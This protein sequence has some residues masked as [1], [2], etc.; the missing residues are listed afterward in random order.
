MAYTQ[1]NPFSRK[2]PLKSYADKFMAS[3]QPVMDDIRQDVNEFAGYRGRDTW[4]DTVEDAF[5]QAPY[6][7]EYGTDKKYPYLSS[8]HHT[9]DSI[10]NPMLTN[11]RRSEIVDGTE[12]DEGILTIAEERKRNQDR[13]LGGGGRNIGTR[14]STF[15]GPT[16]NKPSEKAAK[17][18]LKRHEYLMN[19]ASS[20]EALKAALSTG[21]RPNRH[22]AMVRGEMPVREQF[23][24]DPRLG[25]A[26]NI[27]QSY[28]ANPGGQSLRNIHQFQDLRDRASSAQ[29][30]T[31]ATRQIR[32]RMR[33][34]PTLD[35]RLGY[36]PRS[37]EGMFDTRIG[38]IY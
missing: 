15:F 29:D 31:D 8:R 22:G 33:F 7:P 24:I 6:A 26:V 4:G 38:R 20:E 1:N 21:P 14:G 10:H 11:A 35:T 18:A 13:L 9:F 27:D 36:D 2:S 5:I 25:S 28:A 32:D 17:Q 19:A 16:F 37:G 34:M 3:T 12:M 23:P 30:L